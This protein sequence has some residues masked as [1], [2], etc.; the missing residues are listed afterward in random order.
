MSD[1]LALTEDLLRRPSVSPEDHGCLGVIGARL[2]AVGFL[3]E[4]LAFPPV[5][6]LWSRRGTGRPL[7]C[8]AGHTDVV[9]TG[10]R[11]EWH[12]DPFEPVIR[13]GILYGRGSAD[14]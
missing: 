3:N 5:E 13:D 8:F 6:N 12:T 2:E 4:T 1:T 14:M 11:E 10:P 9:P 7:L